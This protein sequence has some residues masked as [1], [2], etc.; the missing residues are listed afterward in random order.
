MSKSE[1]SKKNILKRK[2]N[3]FNVIYYCV[4]ITDSDF[5]NIDTLIT[6]HSSSVQHL[7]VLIWRE[8]L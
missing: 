7:F 1:I 6:F 2:K 8:N 5:G 3:Q 4:P